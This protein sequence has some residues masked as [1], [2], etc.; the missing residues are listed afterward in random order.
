MASKLAPALRPLLR[1]QQQSF[2][3]NG[4]GAF[5]PQIRKLVFEFCD[6][7]ASSANLR[8]YIHNHLEDLARA[9]PHVE[10]VVRQRSHREPV[11][12]GLYI[13]NRDKVI[14]LK[15][16]EV[17]GISNKVQLLLDS[18]GAKIKPLKRLT[19]ESQTEATRGIWS[20]LHVEEPF[21]I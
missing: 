19:V 11:I 1:A 14:G 20:G 6:N 12:R 13:N 15:D 21:R 8:T 18:S 17:T 7:W 5:I 3:A 16:F 4:H 10:F 9:N 2:P